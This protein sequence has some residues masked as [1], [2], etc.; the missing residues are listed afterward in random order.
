MPTLLST[1]VHYRS[2]MSSEEGLHKL[3]VEYGKDGV[4]TLLFN[5]MSN[6]CKSSL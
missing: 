4:P 6:D 5:E 1:H 2:T 3:E